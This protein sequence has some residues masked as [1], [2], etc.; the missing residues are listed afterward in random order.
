MTSTLRLAVI[1]DGHKSCP[2]VALC[3][4]LQFILCTSFIESTPKPEALCVYLQ[5]NIYYFLAFSD[6]LI[7]FCSTRLSI[8][9]YNGLPNEPVYST[10]RYQTIKNTS[11]RKPVL[12]PFSGNSVQ[13][14]VLVHWIKQILVTL[15]MVISFIYVSSYF[16]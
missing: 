9:S 3:V 4:H 8:Y 6:K 7:H 15:R 12:S 14:S 13:N 5:Q 1:L 11:F 10:F 2:T 16:I